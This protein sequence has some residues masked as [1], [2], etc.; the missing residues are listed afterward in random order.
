MRF[1][2]LSHTILCCQ[3]LLFHPIFLEFIEFYLYFF[4]QAYVSVAFL[5]MGGALSCVQQINWSKFKFP[6]YLFRFWIQFFLILSIF[7]FYVDR[8]P[9]F[10]LSLES[11]PWVKNQHQHNGHSSCRYRKFNIHMANSIY[12]IYEHLLDCRTQGWT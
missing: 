6:S 2:V 12:S 10:F 8:T 4:F 5:R 11:N 7:F 3:F 1:C 9:L